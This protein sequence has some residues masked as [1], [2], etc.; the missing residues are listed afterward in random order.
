MDIHHCLSLQ[1][2][3]NSEEFYYQFERVKTSAGA[4][5]SG[6]PT[7]LSYMS[8][9]KSLFRLLQTAQY[10]NLKCFLPEGGNFYTARVQKGEENTLAFIQNVILLTAAQDQMQ[11][12]N[13]RYSGLC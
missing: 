7:T 6:S 3:L 10:L 1:I 13:N 4:E 9:A 2:F 11:Q 12:V 8:P 5:S